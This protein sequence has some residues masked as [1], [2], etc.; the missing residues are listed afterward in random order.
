MSR[1][2]TMGA[3]RPHLP[4]SAPSVLKRQPPAPSHPIGIRRTPS[5]TIGIPRHPSAPIEAHRH[6]RPPSASVGFHRRP[7]APIGTQRC[8]TSLPL[9]Q[10]KQRER[11]KLP[12][13]P[14]PRGL[15][16]QLRWLSVSPSGE[17]AGLEDLLRRAE[18]Q[19]LIHRK[20]GKRTK[21][22]AQL[23]PLALAERPSSAGACFVDALF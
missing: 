17:R 9:A 1:W 2:G 6:H 13:A 14:A 7:S 19:L 12:L 23:D 16:P 8:P 20:A 3:G 22:D 11:S 18:E 5:A 15:A 21:G 10:A 4:P